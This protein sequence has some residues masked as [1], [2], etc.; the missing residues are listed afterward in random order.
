MAAAAVVGGLSLVG[1][2]LGAAGA[3]QEADARSA[4]AN[5]NASIANQNADLSLQQ[6]TEQE[7]QQREYAYQ[8]LGNERASYGASGVSMSG[9]ALDVLQ[10]SAR[11]AELDALNIRHAGQ[12]KAWQYRSG[13]RLDSMSANAAQSAGQFGVMSA[14]LSGASGAIKAIPSSSPRSSA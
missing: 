9:S 4:A 8:A 3:E 5:Y 6:A 11:N 13:A 2:V 10:E 7:R 14:L 1:G 12:V